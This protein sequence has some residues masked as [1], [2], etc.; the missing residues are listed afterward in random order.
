[1]FMAIFY[2]REVAPLSMLPYIVQP[3][4][5]NIKL[6]LAQKEALSAG[7]YDA[8]DPYSA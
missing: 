1:M 8:S 2:F 3:V 4:I 6:F 7:L 5:G